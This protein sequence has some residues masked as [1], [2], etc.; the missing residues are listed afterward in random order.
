MHKETVSTMTKRLSIATLLAAGLLA[1]GAPAGAGINPGTGILQTSHDLSSSTGRGALYDA[2]VNAD[3]QDRVCVLQRVPRRVTAKSCDRVGGGADAKVRG[4]QRL[5][6]IVP[7]G[8]VD[9]RVTAEAAP[10]H[11]TLTDECL[12][13][14]DSNCKMN[15]PLRSQNHVDAIIAGLGRSWVCSRSARWSARAWCCGSRAGRRFGI[16]SKRNCASKR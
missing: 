14:F 11:F 15:P 12:R 2:G 8:G 9:V 6:E 7:E 13:T 5:L 1:A 10:H 4:E 3:P 16:C